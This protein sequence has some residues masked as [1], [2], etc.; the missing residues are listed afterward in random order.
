M[1]DENDNN[2]VFESSAFEYRVQEDV[3]PGAVLAHIVATDAD[4]GEYG[5]ITYLL[6]RTSTQVNITQFL[7]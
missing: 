3:E 5:K 4:S 6:D 1:L 2:P 7:L